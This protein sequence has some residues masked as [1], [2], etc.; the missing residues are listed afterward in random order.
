MFT[1]LSSTLSDESQAI[2]VTIIPK[3]YQNKR[4]YYC[5]QKSAVS[6]TAWKSY[7]WHASFE[8]IN[9][10]LYDFLV[11]LSLVD[12]H[13]CTIQMVH[14]KPACGSAIAVTITN[15]KGNYNICLISILR[16]IILL[17]FF[18]KNGG[19]FISQRSAYTA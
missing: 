6:A 15:M 8:K 14:H 10:F 3:L 13:I 16:Y 11:G 7:G 5:T 1:L 2:L 12:C 18:F 19:C 9:T 17:N 4:W